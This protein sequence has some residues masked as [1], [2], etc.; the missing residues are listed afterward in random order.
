MIQTFIFLINPRDR[1]RPSVHRESEFTLDPVAVNDPWVE[2]HV[3]MFKSNINTVG[4]AAWST[5]DSHWLAMQRLR[6]DPDR[7]CA[8]VIDCFIPFW[9]RPADVAFGGHFY[10]LYLF[11]ILLTATKR[12]CSR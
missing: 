9:E 10:L 7:V 11:S 12:F 2:Y 6:L 5:Y 3:G 4:K 8:E 1:K